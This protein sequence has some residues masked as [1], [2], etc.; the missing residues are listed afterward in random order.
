MTNTIHNAVTKLERGFTLIEVAVALLVLAVGLL[1]IA[2]MQSSGMQATMKSHQRATAMTQAQDIADRIRTN[3]SALRSMDYVGTIA[4]VAPSPNCQ[5]VS[6]ICTSPQLAAT[7]LFNW[8]TEN[9]ASLPS[10]QGRITCTDIN[11][12]TAT[13]LEAG[14]TCLITVMWDGERSGVTGTGCNPASTSDLSCLRMGITP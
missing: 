5:T 6:N 11:V 9:A 4:T 13:I 2:G 10:G 3:L 12:A 14:T 8:Q 1:G 7:D